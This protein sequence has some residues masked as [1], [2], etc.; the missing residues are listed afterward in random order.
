MRYCCVQRRVA[1]SVIAVASL[2]YLA[3]GAEP[4]APVAPPQAAGYKLKFVDEFDKLDLSPDGRG[5]HTWYEGVWFVHKHPPLAN[6]SAVASILTLKWQNGQDSDDTSITTLSRD[7]HHV[8]A[9]RYG[10]FE[11]RMK[12]D[13]VPGAWPALW[14]IPVQSARGQDTYSGTKEAGEIDIFEGQGDVPHTYYGTIH[15]W[16][17]GHHDSW[18]A[19][20][21]F[22][23]PENVNFSQFHTYGLLWTPGKVTWYL[24]NQP[25]HTEPTPAIVDK[26]DFFI[27]LGMQAGVDWK[28]GNLTGVTATNFSLMVDYV[29]VWQK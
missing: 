15:D 14:L 10:Y 28:Y 24:D 4:F 12:W 3:Q 7:K 6:I 8:K 13:V 18:N 20:N 22:T 17:N 21:H 23:L 9:W 5:M 16:T 19:N 29:R 11:A 1:G 27:V 26:Q 2:V 25:L